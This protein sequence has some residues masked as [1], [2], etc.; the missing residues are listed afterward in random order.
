M[1]D[2]TVD[3]EELLKDNDYQNLRPADVIK[4]V[5]LSA[6]KSQ[7]WID[8]GI[9][10]TGLVTSREIDY[11]N[12]LPA[13]GDELVL[14][15]IEPETEQGFALLSLKKV[16]KEI[17][18]DGLEKKFQ[19]KD[20]FGVVPIDANKGGLLIEVDGVRGFL[21]VSQLSSEHY[22]RVTGADRD[23]ILSRLNQ[24]VKTTIM[25]RILDLDRKQ[26]KL[27]VSEKEAVK[28]MTMDKL[29]ELNVGEIVEGTVTGV[30]DFGIFVNVSGVEGLIH[31]S[32]LSWDRVDNPSK[33]VKLGQSIEAKII[34][35]DADKLSLS[36]KQ[37]SSDPWVSEV[38]EMK[39]GDR[40]KGKVSRVTPFGAFVALTPVVEAL[41]HVSEITADTSIKDPSDI[42]KVGQEYEFTIL[43]L[44][45]STHKLSLSLK[46]QT[47]DVPKAKKEKSENKKSEDSSIKN[48]SNSSDSPKPKAKKVPK[49]DQ[50]AKEPV[51][52]T[53]KK[54]TTKL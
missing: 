25:V 43:S 11:F 29:A 28:E 17:G 38:A 49:K 13:V 20:I 30:V 36:I 9:Y 19:D 18:W 41:V 1:A 52:S 33:I 5:V 12:A 32:E 47:K 51:K 54:T 48:E 8:L 35:I 6:Q 46:D 45:S 15:V 37:L 4:G 24:L 39:V 7:I 34:S 10:G 3:M 2:K 31:I 27:I 26:N 42:L 21:P 23:E 50:P 16:A 44:D 40:I 53:S 14:S 22:P